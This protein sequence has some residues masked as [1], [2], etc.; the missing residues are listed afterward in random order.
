M[1]ALTALAFH[2]ITTGF[3]SQPIRHPH[4]GLLGLDRTLPRQRIGN[5]LF[6]V[7]MLWLPAQSL[8]KMG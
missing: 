8:P 2:A 3:I 1:V 4:L 6:Q 5:N 7:V